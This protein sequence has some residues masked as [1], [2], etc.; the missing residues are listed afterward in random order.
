[1]ESDPERPRLD[2]GEGSGLRRFEPQHVDHHDRLAVGRPERR[3]C[4]F[5]VDP[6][7]ESIAWDLPRWIGVQNGIS[8]EEARTRGFE[9][10]P[11]RDAEEP[12]PNARIPSKSDGRGAGA[13]EGLLRQLLGVVRIPHDP[14][15]VG[16]DL[17]LVGAEYVF[18]IHVSVTLC[19]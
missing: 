19:E 6:I 15:E 18:E 3:Q 9:Q 13:D 11:V 16:V 12:C 4:T 7:I 17:P 8:T 2:P 1:M 10:H 5:Q 14:Q